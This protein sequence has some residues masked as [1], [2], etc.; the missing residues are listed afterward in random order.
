[1]SDLVLNVTREYFDQIKAGTKKHEYRLD[2]PYWRKRL[3]GKVYDRVI[4]VLGYPKANDMSRRLFFPYR[5]YEMKNHTHKH[6]GANEV[7]VFA[8]PLEQKP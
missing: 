6:F 5:G 2:T 3:V 7:T 1:M 4:M 8:I